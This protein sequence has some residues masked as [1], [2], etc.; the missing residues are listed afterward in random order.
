MNLKKNGRTLR[1]LIILSQLHHV[2]VQC[3]FP[4]LL[5]ALVSGDEAI[6]P[7]FTWISTANVVEHLGGKVV[8]AT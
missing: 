8:F 2:P 4:L 5:W 1:E 7:A 6:I 3:I